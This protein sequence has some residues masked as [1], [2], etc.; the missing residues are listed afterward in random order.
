MNLCRIYLGINGL[1]SALVVLVIV[2]DV[3]LFDAGWHR[4]DRHTVAIKSLD[5]TVFS[6]KCAH[7][8]WQEV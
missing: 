6:E 8:V 5:N 3:K 7:M 2:I 4:G 1:H